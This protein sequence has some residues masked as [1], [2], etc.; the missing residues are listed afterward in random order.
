MARKKIALKLRLLVLSR[1]R[2][3]NGFSLARVKTETPFHP[4]YWL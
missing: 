2:G 3:V 4:Y 1:Q